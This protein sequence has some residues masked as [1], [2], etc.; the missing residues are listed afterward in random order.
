[1]SIESHISELREKL[2]STVKLVA[3][4]K[5]KPAEDIMAAYQVGQRCF[6]ENRPQELATKAV[7]LPLDIEWHFIGHLQTNKLKMVLPYAAMIHSIDSMRLLEAVDRGAAALG[8][9]MPCLLE[10]HIASEESKQGFSAEE[11]LSIDFAAFHNVRFRGLMGMASFVDD[12]ELVRA[13]FRSLKELQLRVAA[14]HP[15]LE[16]FDQISMGMSQDY[17]IAIEEGATIVRIGSTIFGTRNA[18]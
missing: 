7:A 5:F 17:H 18:K 4:S 3:V 2:P 6:G 8:K 16:E 10:V 9:V 13:E 14:L 12:M 1:M 15:E 11:V